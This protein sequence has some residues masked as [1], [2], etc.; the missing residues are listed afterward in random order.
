MDLIFRN[1]LFCRHKFLHIQMPVFASHKLPI[2][3]IS[4]EKKFI[5][6][7]MKQRNKKNISSQMTRL[8][9]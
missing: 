8:D 4:T 2:S 3:Q 7:K 9:N 6:A 1:M 5:L